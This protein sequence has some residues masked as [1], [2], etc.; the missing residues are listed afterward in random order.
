MPNNVIRV[1][2]VEIMSLSD[3][4]LEFDLCNFFPTIPEDSWQGHESDLTEEHKVRFN[5]GSFLIRSQ[6]RTILVDSGSGP[7]VAV[8]PGATDELAARLDA[9]DA[10]PDLVII[11]HFDFDHAGGLVVEDGPDELRPAIAGV[12]VIGPAAAVA[13][14]L[15]D[16]TDDPASRVIAALDG[17][18]LM[19]VYEDGD[20]PAP[21]LRLRAAPGHRLGHSILEIGP[22][23]VHMVDIVHHPLLMND[24]VVLIERV[25]EDRVPRCGR[26]GRGVPR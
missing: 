4:M 1:G 22:S 13:E 16:R 3:G 23:L 7:F 15:G 12:P 20:E 8:W 24:G 6:G 17:A 2:N 21:G 9:E 18:G 19:E 11:T 26:C 10:T 14:A 5:L 25:G